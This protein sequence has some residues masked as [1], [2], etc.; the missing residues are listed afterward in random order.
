MTTAGKETPPIIEMNGYIIKENEFNK[1]VALL[2]EVELRRCG[3]DVLNVSAT[4]NDSLQD[5]VQRANVAK[6]DIFVAIHAN[7]FDGKFDKYDPEGVEVH[8]YGKG[9]EAEKLAEFVL[10]ELIQGTTQVNR[11]IKVSNFYVLSKTIMPAILSESLFM[12]NK[13]EAL[14]MLDTDFQHE[15]ARE[16]AKG[17]CNYFGVDYIES[18]VKTDVGQLEYYKQKFQDLKDFIDE[19]INYGV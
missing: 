17:I 4:D 1:A 11:G 3:I 12:D 10:A 7:A 9:G 13:R 5:R 19:T 15:V 18:G 16:H 2:L 6:A 8:I 14:L